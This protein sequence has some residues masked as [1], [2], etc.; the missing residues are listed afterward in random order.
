MTTTKCGKCDYVYAEDIHQNSPLV[1][2]KCGSKDITMIHKDVYRISD[3]VYGTSKDSEGNI[4]GER[5]NITDLNTNA[6]IATDCGQ[7]TRLNINRE[8]RVDGFVE[9]GNYT[10]SFVNA[11]NKFNNTKY[12][13]RDK[14]FED[15]DY[16]D[17]II[18][19]GNENINVQI[20]HFDDEIVSEIG[21]KKQFTG[22]R[23]LQNFANSIKNA[24][25]KKSLIDP[26]LKKNTILL[27][28][29]PS[30]LG[31]LRRQDILTEEFDF[32]GF[33]DVWIAPFGIREEP[34][35]LTRKA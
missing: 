11:Y 21:R 15:S 5:I 32:R 35:G 7:P 25:E 33:K 29:I 19:S 13:I 24:I 10:K 2:P 34:F 26:E 9:E 3:E 17:R 23:L 1:C 6:V 12:K 16:A 20:R 31:E 30:P 27:L 22:Q 18:F 28:I 8:R 4:S 14:E